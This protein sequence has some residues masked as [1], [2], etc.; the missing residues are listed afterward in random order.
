MSVLDGAAVAAKMQAA[1]EEA[2][3]LGDDLTPERAERILAAHFPVRRDVEPP[4]RCATCRWAKRATLGD[5][6]LDYSL[7]SAVGREEP[8]P[9]FGLEN[10]HEEAIWVAPDFG[11]VTWEAKR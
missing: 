6:V 10:P 1:L 2:A 8:P 4:P 5:A 7:C 3:R 9:L 11:C